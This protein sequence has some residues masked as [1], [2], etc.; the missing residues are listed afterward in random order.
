MKRI[1]RYTLV[2]LIAIGLALPAYVI[3]A[4]DAEARPKH[5]LFKDRDRDGVPD[6][7]DLCPNRK[8]DRDGYKDGDGCPELKGPQPR[9]HVPIRK[10]VKR[11]PPHRPLL[12]IHYILGR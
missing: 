1:T 11:P 10:S 9:K 5:R 2:A 7:Y 12:K 6:R 8:E 3:S 4:T